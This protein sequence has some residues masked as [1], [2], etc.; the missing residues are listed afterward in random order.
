[1]EPLAGALLL[2]PQSPATEAWLSWASTPS[3]DYCLLRSSPSSSQK[4]SAWLLG[5]LQPWP[6]PLT[7][8]HDGGGTLLG[9][10][11]QEA[12]LSSQSWL[13]GYTSDGNTE[14]LGGGEQ[15]QQKEV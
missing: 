14:V 11:N 9:L 8:P 15:A 10:E 3:C 13:M 1:M 2:Y 7:S 5:P 4:L 6:R 12:T